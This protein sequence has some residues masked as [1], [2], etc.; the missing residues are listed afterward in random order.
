MDEADG[1]RGTAGARAEFFASGSAEDASVPH[2][3]AASWRR[4]L[5]AGVDAQS[6]QVAYHNDLDTSSRLVRCSQPIIERL[7]QETAALPLSIAL[8]DSKAQILT[9]VDTGRDAAQLL[10][11]VSFAPGFDYAEG[12]VGTNGVGTVFELGKSVQINGPEHYHEELQPFSCAGAPIRNP[13]TGRIEGVLDISCLAQ[14]ASPIM[15]SLTR[16]AALDI[17]R[18]LLLDRSLGQQALFEA[19]VRAEGRARGA[20]MAVSGS[21]AMSNTLAQSLFDPAELR[22]IQDHANYRMP[23]IDPAIEEIEL[24]TGK[25]V[26]IRTTRV[27]A[28]QDTAGVVLELKLCSEESPTPLPLGQPPE[29]RVVPRPAVPAMSSDLKGVFELKKL[30]SSGQSLLWRKACSD[31]ARALEQRNALLV[32]GETGAGKL[33]LVTEMYHRVTPGGRSVV[34]E[35]ASIAGDS[36]GNAEEVM[37]ATVL[38]TLYIFRNIDALSTDGVERLNTFLMALADS[39]GRAFAA[40][41]VSDAEVDSELPFRDL[42]VHFVTAVTVPPLRHR[43]DD[44]PTVVTQVLGKLSGSRATRVSPAAMRVICRYSWPR[45]IHQLEEA[46]RAALLK[47]PVGELQPEDLP[48]YCHN[49]ARHQLTGLESIERDAIVKALHDAGGNRVQAA[50]DLGIARSSLYRKLKSYGISTI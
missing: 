7:R 39:D 43:L 28:G 29:L 45:N 38:P 2:V 26:R 30:S 46:L 11:K 36:Y 3:V 8:T 17:E 4:S 33:S 27:L 25:V 1:R 24:T 42:L 9:R 10:D 16:S 22:T 19:F 12:N 37:E 18:N 13:L 50:A 6:M 21:I 31:I 47:R 48:G 14:H 23:R 44:I 32:M 35:A 20:V 41:T 5:T 49:S 40:A 34:I 15:Q